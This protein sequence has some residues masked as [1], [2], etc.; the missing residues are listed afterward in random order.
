MRL[1]IF[2]HEASCAPGTIGDWCAAREVVPLL[3]RFH[4]GETL[5]A[6][7]E[8]DALLILGGAMNAYQDA[9]F[10]H[11][12]TVRDFTRVA[13]NSNKKVCGI[14]LGAQI[15]ADALGSR[16]VRAPEQERGWIEIVRRE[17]AAS[18]PLL[19][20]LPQRARFISWHDDTFA[21]PD[22]AVHGAQSQQCAA[23]A[24][25]FG[26]HAL[27]LQFHPEAGA[28]IVAGWIEDEPE[29]ERSGLR[30]E[31]FPFEARFERQRELLF[32]ALDAW[33]S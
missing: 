12:Q 16:V 2:Q 17:E 13:L 29:A 15:M 32:A 5:P 25:A 28:S 18:S 1:H 10:P 11:L 22:G 7:N 20:W 3:T 31:F 24:F 9:D 14:C 27:A 26:D 19:R 30:A 23:Q 33:I 21:V 6:L 8:V 4:L